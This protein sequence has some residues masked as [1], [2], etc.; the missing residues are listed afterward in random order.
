MPVTKAYSLAN[1]LLLLR[2]KGQ[3]DLLRYF[4]KKKVCHS[5]HEAKKIFKRFK[6][7]GKSGA[8]F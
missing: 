2:E 8:T 3:V 7:V 4:S 6:K 1:T 5:S